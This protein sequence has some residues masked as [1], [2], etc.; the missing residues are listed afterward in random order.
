MFGIIDHIGQRYLFR[1][2]TLNLYKKAMIFIMAK[3]LQNKLKKKRIHLQQV[4]NHY[5]HNLLGKIQMLGTENE[6]RNYGCMNY[7][8][9]NTISLV[10][11]VIHASRNSYVISPYRNI[12]TK[13][14][15]Y[16]KKRQDNK[17]T[18]KDP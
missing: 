11:A 8:F 15:A 5:E 16:K 4:Y 3:L 13:K 18:P 17:S 9:G 1:A 12:M 7:G 6:G 14:N 10:K 2:T